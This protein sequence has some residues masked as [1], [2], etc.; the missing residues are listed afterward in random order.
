MKCIIVLGRTKMKNQDVRMI[1]RSH[2]DKMFCFALERN[3]CE[4]VHENFRSSDRD[5]S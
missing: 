5:K 2:V 3:I 4:R 1:N